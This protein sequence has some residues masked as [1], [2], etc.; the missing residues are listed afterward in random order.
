MSA[1]PTVE[2]THEQ[3]KRSVT[4]G[5]VVGVVVLAIAVFAGLSVVADVRALGDSLR[6]FHWP[7]VAT[8][9]ALVLGNYALRFA[10]WQ[11]YL[12]RLE[13]SVPTGLSALI[14]TAG[15]LMSVTPGKMG[16]VF[17]SVLLKQYRGV[18][19]TRTASIVV[20]E[21]LMDLVALVLLVAL[22]SV[23]FPRGGAVTLL[24]GLVVGALLLGCAWRGLALWVLDV[25]ERLPIVGRWVPRLREAYDALFS[26][27]RPAPL[28]V[29][30]VLACAGW[31]LECFA[32]WQ[33]VRGFAGVQIG[34]EGATFSYATSTLAGALAML[35]GGLGVTEASM[36]G[37]LSNT[38]EN[39]SLAVAGA[40]TILVRL[41]TLWFGVS[42]GGL[43]LAALNLVGNVRTG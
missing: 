23:A 37:L 14:F 30:T 18:P 11:Y 8:A 12:A 16:E 9:L 35:P 3:A 15:F 31:T 41:A 39:V 27:T 40:A 7:A 28:V 4:T 43:A 36:A 1:P 20:A 38:G 21:R 17:K 10:R 34:V 5:R 29:G 42:L 6:T 25:L 33:I 19:V 13:V 22:G 26:L 2:A 32:T 24:G